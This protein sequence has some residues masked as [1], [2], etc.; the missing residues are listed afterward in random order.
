MGFF[1][2]CVTFL[3]KKKPYREEKLNLKYAW[4]KM[5][6]TIVSKTIIL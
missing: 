1:L 6:D 5:V 3:K 4:W 2:N